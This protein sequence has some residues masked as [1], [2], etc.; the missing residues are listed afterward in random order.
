M[1][2]LLVT[3]RLLVTMDA[4]H[5]TIEDGALAIDKGA[6]VALGPR[7]EIE[8]RYPNPARRI[9]GEKFVLMPGFVDGHS[10]AGHGL[11]R[12]LGGDDFP[13]WRQ[14]CRDIYMLGATPEF[15][16]AEARLSS[17]E[18]LKAG[19]T[20]AVAYLGGGDE[21][22][23]SDGVDVPTAYAAAYGEAGGRLILGIGPTRPP[24][25]KTY[26]RYV[27]GAREEFQVD[28][29]TQHETCRRLL[30]DLPSSRIG[31]A[32][33]TPTVNPEIHRGPHF[34]E[35]CD[36]ARRMKRLAKDHDAVLMMDGQRGG[37]V[38]FAVRELGIVDARTLLSHALDITPA[39]V[40]LVAETGATVA[41]NPLSGS[42]V[43]GRCPVP[44][45]LEAGG[46]VIMCSDGLAPDCGADMF[47]VMRMGGQYHRAMARDPHLLPPGRL[48]HMTTSDPAAFFGLA[49]RGTLEIGKRADFILVDMDKPHL[50]PATM[51]LFQLHYAATGQDVDTVVVDGE[52]V[53]EGRKL[54]RV[55]EAAIVAAAK[56]EAQA[57]LDRTGLRALTVTPESFWEDRYD[58]AAYLG[59]HQAPIAAAVK[60]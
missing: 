2:D 5:R 23:R 38:E 1:T 44:E 19:V 51:P 46:R 28:F 7:A 58:R 32:L 53:M 9:G 6:I 10:H 37:T 33:T 12:T 42:A 57:M 17:I 4:A 22:N 15:W 13:V 49:D 39:E 21:N 20:T 34:A 18:R 54:S 47:R 45:I 30:R 59:P 14:A 55:D 41:N 27:K 56:R 35:L 40:R 52:V 60:A 31:V 26:A 3:A 48:L 16:A 43:W 25:P 36:V 29:E 24:F 8:A 11:V 50:A